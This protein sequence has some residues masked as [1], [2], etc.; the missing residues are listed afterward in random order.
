MAADH[1]RQALNTYAGVE[2]LLREGAPQVLGVLARRYGDFAGAEDAVQEALLTAALRWPRDGV[3]DNP[4][5][6]LLQ[7]A[8]RRLPPSRF[9]RRVA[10]HKAWPR[11]TV[12]ANGPS[13]F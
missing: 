13:T 6:W 12:T 11:E 3:P 1:G 5:A 4:N 2:D 9:E 7:A 8:T 10:H